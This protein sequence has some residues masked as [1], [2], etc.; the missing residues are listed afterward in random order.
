MHFVNR[1][2]LLGT[3]GDRMLS[4]LTRI[5]N[6]LGY[7]NHYRYIIDHSTRVNIA[8]ASEY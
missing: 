5:S 3:Q 1:T 7:M 8:F 6:T 4:W 2:K